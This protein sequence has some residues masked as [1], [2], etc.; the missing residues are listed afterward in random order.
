MSSIAVPVKTEG[1]I[2]LFYNNFKKELALKGIEFSL[3][4]NDI[5]DLFLDQRSLCYY[6][7]IR[8]SFLPME[9]GKEANAVLGKIHPR[10]GFV[11]GNV[12]WLDRRIASMKG[13]L[14][15]KRFLKICYGVANHNPEIK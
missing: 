10:L 2:E 8:L 5:V 4:F 12:K 1:S 11:K 7:G 15:E 6:S 13:N 14:S 3:S 9:D